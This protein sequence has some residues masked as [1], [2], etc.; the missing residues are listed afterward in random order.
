MTSG[1]GN[2]KAIFL[3]TNVLVY[4]N[5]AAA[6]LR[7]AVLQAIIT[8]AKDGAEFWI[9]RQIIREYLA[10]LT[11]QQTYTAPVPIERLITEVTQFMTQFQVAEDGPEVTRN[12]L[13]LLAQFPGGGKQIHDTNIVATMQAYGVTQILTNNV[14]DFTRFSPLITVVPL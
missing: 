12:L 11:R 4:A 13:A 9:S 14:K 6:P 5:V 10:A 2:A 3:D 8:Y 1:G 7:S